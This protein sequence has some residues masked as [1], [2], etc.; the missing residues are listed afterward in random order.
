MDLNTM[1]VITLGVISLGFITLGVISLGV[2]PPLKSYFKEYNY[3]TPK[4]VVSVFS[5]LL[6]SFIY[7][8]PEI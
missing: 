7:K 8:V 3:L 1:G 5:N 4:V 6:K 2:V